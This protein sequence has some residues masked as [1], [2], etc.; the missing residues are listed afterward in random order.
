MTKKIYSTSVS[1][2]STSPCPAGGNHVMGEKSW[3]NERLILVQ[4]LLPEVGRGTRVL[5]EL[6]GMTATV[7]EGIPA[8]TPQAAG[9]TAC[10]SI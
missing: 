3:V 4:Q 9:A 8:R 6:A 7:T 5:R 2:H 10:H 1:Q